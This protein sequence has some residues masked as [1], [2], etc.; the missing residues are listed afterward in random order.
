MII[1][2]HNFDIQI[3]D[4]LG[5]TPLHFSAINGSYQLVKYFVDTGTDINLKGIKGTNCLHIATFYGKFDLCKTLRNKNNFD[6][7]I[8]N[9]DGWT[10]L[11][12]SASNGS[13]ELV[14]YFTDEG[15]DINLKTY[16]GR[17][18]LHIATYFEH[19]NLCKMLI[20]KHNFDVQMVDNNGWTALHS[21]AKKGSYQLFKYFADIGTDITLKTNNG[22]NY[23]HIAA[24]YGH[25][26]LCKAVINKHNFDSGIP[27]SDGRTALHFSASSG[28]YELV[29]YFAD[30]GIDI[31][32]KTNNG[33]NCLHIATY[34]EHLD[35]C[36]KLI[37]KHNFDVQMADNNGWTPLHF[38][39]RKGSFELFKYFAD[40][41]TEVNLKINNGSNCLHVA[42]EHGFLNLCN[43]LI[44]K[45]NFDV[46]MSDY[47]GWT[48]LHYSVS[49]CSYQL[50]KYFAD[51]G[52][53]IKLKANDGKNCLHILQNM[54]T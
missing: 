44:N 20:T 5:A 46:K 51:T 21:S 14:K 40:I 6:A 37:K 32:L 1:D 29:K 11:H 7:R 34:C 38:S 53:D 36:K 15:I 25:L 50:V 35:L 16:D 18:Y 23:L 10:A 2:K 33:M 8:P 49:I 45:H 22:S 24:E 42:A 19:L 54:Y 27:N 48:A 39:A 12:F 47:Y 43:T 52:I 13:Y 4:I 30:A 17:N 41:G 31:N 28:N 3:S 26:S 9:S